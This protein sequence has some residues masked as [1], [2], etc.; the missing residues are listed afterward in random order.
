MS[1]FKFLEVG[2]RDG[3]QN[4][5]T[6][7]SLEDKI[8]FVKRLSLTGVKRIEIGSFV[9]HKVLSQM[10][11]TEELVEEIFKLQKENQI[12][13]DVHFSALVPNL[14]GLER[15]LSVGIKEIAIFAGCT[16]SFSKKNINC[17]VEESFKIYKEVADIALKAKLKVRGYLSVAFGCPYEGIVSVDRVKNLTERMRNMGVYEVSISDTIG[18]AY[19]EQVKQFLQSFSESEFKNLALHFHN[20]HGMALANILMA[21][22]I[23]V[24]SFDGSVGGLGGCP[25]VGVSSGNVPSEEVFYLLGGSKHP[26]LK[27][28]TEVSVWLE[29]KLQKTLPSAVSASPY[30]RA[31]EK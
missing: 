13:K 25:Y 28:L 1:E 9:S 29:K 18:V 30:Y 24:T 16:D 27:K 6:I 19:P 12:P 23:G 31:K 7:L 14:K 17:T 26:F 10:R 15:A 11:G 22:Q 5:K 8:E 21:Y 3:L 2:P 20:V 4:E